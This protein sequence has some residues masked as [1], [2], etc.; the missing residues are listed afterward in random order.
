VND[1][2]ETYCTTC[3]SSI[4]ATFKEDE[5]V[6]DPAEALRASIVPGLG[7]F[8]VGLAA[9]GI[10]SGVLVT[11]AVLG[12]LAMAVAGDLGGLILVVLGLGAWAA[13]ARDAVAVAGGY[14]KAWLTPRT[15]SVT[16][17]AIII[18]AAFLILKTP[19]GG[20]G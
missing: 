10:L 9:E 13:T 1:P 11:F 6:I 5:E 16:A 19:L 14:D 12:G 17:G 2:S 15:I 4:Y 20:G 8:R 3:G 18:T 7:M